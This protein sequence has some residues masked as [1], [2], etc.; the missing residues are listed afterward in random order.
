M[1][2]SSPATSGLN[3]ISPS[4]S[5]GSWATTITG[6][7]L[8]MSILGGILV[9]DLTV[10]LGTAP[11]NAKS[12][13][14]TLYIAGIAT[15]LTVN[16]ANL[17]TS[18]TIHLATPIT[19]NQGDLMTFVSS[20]NSTPAGTGAISFRMRQTAGSKKSVVYSG[21]RTAPANTG[22]TY[23]GVM[24]NVSSTLTSATITDFQVPWPTS[25]TFRNLFAHWSGAIGAG[26]W[27]VAVNVAGSTTGAPSATLSSGTDASD[28]TNSIHVNAG[29]LVCLQYTPTG[30]PTSLTPQ[31][32]LEFDPDIDGES[33][34][35]FANATTGF[36]APVTNYEV[37][38]GSGFGYSTTESGR[39]VPSFGCIYRKLYVLL[40]ANAGSTGSY[41][42]KLRKNTADTLLTTTVAGAVQTTNNDTSDSVTANAGDVVDMQISNIATSTN[43]S[44]KFSLVQYIAP[45]VSGGAAAFF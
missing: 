17:A 10:V 36:T 25:G 22:V 42:W 39:Q 35:A 16:I 33:V 24:T 19:V 9:N 1:T 40:G 45:A 5:F 2:T 29:D 3:Y 8:P 26:S 28:T 37:L 38:F 20:P 7:K 6:E 15:A 21:G 4:V 13:D 41:T 34:L 23:S 32:G 18:A 31:I 43:H 11:G 30:T 14:F 44:Q 27:N 12:W